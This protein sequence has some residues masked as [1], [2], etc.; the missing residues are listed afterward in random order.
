MRSTVQAGKAGSGALVAGRARR[1]RSPGRAIEI[2]EY[3][4][5][6][7]PAVLEVLRAAFGSW[8]HGM[9]GVD[10]A[11]FF[12]WKLEGCPFG[13]QVSLVAHAPDGLVGFVSQLPWPFT[14]AGR[15][16]SSLRGM[17]LAVH[18][19]HRGRGIS[20]MIM[21]AVIEGTPADVALA[22][23][24]PNEQSRPGLLKTG[25][26]DLVAL[27]RF[28]APHRAPGPVV[29]RT[30]GRRPRPP[31]HLPVEAGTAGEVLR[32]DEYASRVLREIAR[33]DDRLVTS[34]DLDYLRWR[35]GRFAL[36]RAFV[37]DPG[38]EAPGIVIFRVRRRGRLWVSEICE[39]LVAGNDL[40]SARRLLGKVRAAAPVDLLRATFCSD[41]EAARCGFLRVRGGSLLTVRTIQPGLPDLAR[42]QSWG[43]SFGDLELL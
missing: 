18:P 23:N 16:L 14:A 4:P 37:A 28:V 20:T 15:S 30:L 21:H 24:N 41:R 43:L 29:M 42:P 3:E 12:R 39:L 19:S 7:E 25:R 6:D 8:P 32:D 26:R 31:E 40:R 1:A 9:E 13:R 27:P 2:R 5:A 38:A 10:A 36:Y 22:W 35:Y 17:D 11:E 34:R 33:T